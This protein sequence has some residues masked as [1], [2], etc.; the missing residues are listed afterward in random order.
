MKNII[1]ELIKHELSSLD[2]ILRALEKLGLVA[3]DAFLDES[4]AWC[5]YETA[6]DTEKRQVLSELGYDVR[7]LK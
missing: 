7:G 3:K 1:N 6:S 4:E 5:W 2:D